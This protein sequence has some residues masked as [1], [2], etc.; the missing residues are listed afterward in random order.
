MDTILERIKN[1]FSESIQTKISTA[2]SLLSVIS[3]AG[4]KIVQCLLDNHKIMT[5]GNGG[6]ACDALR[7]TS[8]MLNR[9]KH[10]RPGLP[11]ISLGAD[12]ASLTAI[13][14]DYDYSDIFAK[15]VRAL[16]HAGD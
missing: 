8:Q 3:Y 9:F 11:V 4:Q 12:I 5:C 10:E 13:A 6:S 1:N 7:F 15:Q 14:N 2:D 16:G